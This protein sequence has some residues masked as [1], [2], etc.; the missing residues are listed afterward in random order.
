MPCS[1]AVNKLKQANKKSSV[2]AKE[3]ITT[4]VYTT[5]DGKVEE[6]KKPAAEVAQLVGTEERDSLLLE[7]ILLAQEEINGHIAIMRLSSSVVPC[8]LSLLL[9]V[10][11]ER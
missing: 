2:K 9:I 4:T 6:D 5:E 8:L 3:E 10:T 1:A 11:Y 7:E